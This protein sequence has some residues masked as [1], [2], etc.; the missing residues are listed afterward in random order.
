MT[1]RISGQ[2]VN[3]IARLA[4]LHL[5]KSEQQEAARYLAEILGYVD[6]IAELKIQDV[7]L[8]TSQH[9]EFSKLRNDE[10]RPF[11]DIQRLTPK[12]RFSEGNCMV[13]KGV[14]ETTHE[15]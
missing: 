10:A 4:R 2:E 13:T 12:Y 15:S 3:K 14:F 5:E 7:S 1:N 11:S 8:F 9:T 6:T